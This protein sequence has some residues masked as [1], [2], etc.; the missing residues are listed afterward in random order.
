MSKIQINASRRDIMQH[1]AMAALV[2]A[3]LVPSLAHAAPSAA[4]FQAKTLKDA[5]A[6][7]GATAVDAAGKITIG[8]PDIAENGAV[9]PVSITTTI[10]NASEIYLFVEKNPFPLAASF[11]LP[12]GTEASITTRVKMGQTSN[13][14]AVVK[15]DGKLFSSVKETKVTLGGC[16]G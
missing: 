6:G 13:I 8:A 3:G 7:L 15:A 2:A 5:L 12:A 14:Y 4:T 1:S 11:T 16:G 10:P 9:V